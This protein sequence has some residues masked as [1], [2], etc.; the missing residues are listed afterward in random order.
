LINPHAEIQKISALYDE[1][2]SCAFENQFYYVIGIAGEQALKYFLRKK[3]RYGC[4]EYLETACL[5]Y[6]LWEANT[7]VDML[8]AQYS[9]RVQ[10]GFSRVNSVQK[11]NS[12]SNAI[13]QATNQILGNAQTFRDKI[14]I[15]CEV[16]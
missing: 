7:K 8:M 2:I 11:F 6:T 1:A 16:S 10:F 5:G 12:T 13:I 4:L 15:L 14:S 9:S 3:I